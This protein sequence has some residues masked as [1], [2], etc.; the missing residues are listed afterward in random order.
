MRI[1]LANISGVRPSK[2]VNIII[3]KISSTVLSGALYTRLNF[4]CYCAVC[5]PES[6]WGISFDPG[7]DPCDVI[8]VWWP[9]LVGTYHPEE[10]LWWRGF[11]RTWCSGLSTCVIHF[12]SP[13]YSIWKLSVNSIIVIATIE[14]NKS[15]YCFW[16]FWR[17]SCIVHEHLLE[18]GTSFV[19]FIFRDVLNCVLSRDVLSREICSVGMFCRERS[20][21]TRVT[22]WIANKHHRSTYHFRIV[23]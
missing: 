19:R 15:S 18:W 12:H 23:L 6:D 22:V 13:E 11:L 10:I 7:E 1:K 16:G 17:T 4:G 20:V 14:W 21:P 5:E 8:R 3:D 9:F 2:Y